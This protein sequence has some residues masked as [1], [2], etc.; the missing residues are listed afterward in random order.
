MSDYR[1]TIKVRNA[2]M[3]RAIEGIGHTVSSFAKA[4]GLWPNAVYGLVAMTISP[5]D[6]NGQW[7]P[8]VM[9][10]CEQ[11]NILPQDLFT[12]RQMAAIERN[13]V[14][15]ELDEAALEALTGHTATSEDHA[16]IADARRLLAKAV[17]ELTPREQLVLQ[18]RMEDVN[19][20]EVGVEMGVVPE[21]VRQIEAKAHRKLMGKLN[22]HK[23]SLTKLPWGAAQ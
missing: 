11:A 15:R 20:R 7:R 3:L 18:R 16:L 5:V 4:H 23:E 12:P 8:A 17:S 10:L 21:R 9:A 13:T 22:K 2:R 1:V 19:L 6:R 14:E